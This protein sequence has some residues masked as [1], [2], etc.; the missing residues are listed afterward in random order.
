MKPVIETLSNGARLV[1]LTMP[2]V[3]SVAMGI[4][5]TVG[6]RHEPARL[7]GISHFLEHLLFKGTPRRSARK[8]SEEIEGIGGDINAQTSEERT[9]YYATS[10][11]AHFPR[12]C[13]V[14]LDMYVHPKLA[15]KDVEL[16]RGVIAEEIQMYKDEHEQHVQE[17]LQGIF[18]P[19]HSLGRPITGTLDSISRMKREDFLAYRSSH[20]HAGNTLISAAGAV[21]HQ[22]L[23]EQVEKSLVPL[24]P[25][26]P[27]H[28]IKTPVVK[29]DIEVLFEQRQTE[30]TQVSLGLPAPGAKAAERYAIGLLHIMMGGN[31][32]SRLFQDLRE[33]RGWCYSVATD[34]QTFSDTGMFNVSLGL[35]GKNLEKCLRIVLQHFQDFREK[36]CRESELIRAKEYVIGSSSISLE[37]SGV[38]NSRIAQSLI[39]HGKVISTEEWQERLRAVTVKEIQDMAVRYL[40]ATSAKLAVIG[41]TANVDRLTDLLTTGK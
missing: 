3:Q 11:A 15:Q 13:D 14:L 5:A 24:P 1:T 33:R 18:W 37:R 32:S 19:N 27:P 31:S 39:I 38:Q 35:D 28:R 30:Q 2:H 6:S 7:N 26:N 41:P 10:P 23:V 36:P 16:E 40:C 9:C 12:V 22:R 20:Y 4:W 17:L 34:M 25:K 29:K 8:I 21:D